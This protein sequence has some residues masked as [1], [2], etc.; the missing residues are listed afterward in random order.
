MSIVTEALK[1]VEK[2]P[3]QDKKMRP[4]LPVIIFI[5][6]TVL[7]LS[8]LTF[9]RMITVSPQVKAPVVK[10]E[11]YLAKEEVVKITLEAL[12]IGDTSSPNRMPHF[13]KNSLSD[14]K[15]NGIAL[16]QGKNFAVINNRIFQQGDQISNAQVTEIREDSVTLNE[17]GQEFR[18]SL[19]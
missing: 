9:K 7:I 10:K 16:M 4:S 1:R 6:G 18:L 14:F 19:K 5:S 11:S 2:K 3:K 8:S 17:D 12:S 13:G 15:L